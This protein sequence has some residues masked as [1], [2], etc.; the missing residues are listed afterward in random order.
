M[1][2]REVLEFDEPYLPRDARSSTVDCIQ[3]RLAA[4]QVQ[5]RTVQGR[6][7]W[8][9]QDTLPGED[10]DDGVA[11]DL[12]SIAEPRSASY[13]LISMPNR[14]DLDFINQQLLRLPSYTK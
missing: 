10:A 8:A 13:S 6:Q 2:I 9:S 3:A 7:P 5:N 4:I 14:R 11:G 12:Q 1:K